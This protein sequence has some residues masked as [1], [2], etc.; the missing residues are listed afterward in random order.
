MNKAGQNW[1]RHNPVSF[2]FTDSLNWTEKSKLPLTCPKPGLLKPRPKWD[3]IIELWGR[4]NFYNYTKPVKWEI[5]MISNIIFYTNRIM[6][7]SVIV[8]YEPT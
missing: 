8:G 4:E 1:S 6:K 2:T 7:N 3:R 5:S